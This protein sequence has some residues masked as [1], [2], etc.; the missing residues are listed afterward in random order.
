MFTTLP[1]VVE[2][3]AEVLSTCDAAAAAAWEAAAMPCHGCAA[4]VGPQALYEVLESLSPLPTPPPAASSGAT[5]PGAWRGAATEH[6]TEPAGG[7]AAA[8][9]LVRARDDAAL[10][11]QAPPGQLLL[12]TVDVLN[13]VVSDSFLFGRIAAVHALSD[14]FAMG[15]TPSV[16]L[17]IVQVQQPCPC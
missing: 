11:P 1:A 15:A 7:M 8:A 6:L 16:A 2:A 14:C 4:K 3:P 9:E 10:L 13:A 5:M 12:Q 17:A